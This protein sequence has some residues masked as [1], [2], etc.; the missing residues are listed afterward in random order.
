MAHA[1]APRWTL[2]DLEGTADVFGK[3]RYSEEWQPLQDAD[4]RIAELAGLMSSK[5]D[6]LAGALQ[7][8]PNLRRP[9][10]FQ[11]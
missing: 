10:R 8:S 2:D 9:G 11:R 1:A 6:E 7:M 3:G 4:P 5:L